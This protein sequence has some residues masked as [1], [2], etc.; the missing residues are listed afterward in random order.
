MREYANTPQNKSCIL[1]S[2][3]KVSEQ[4]SILEILQAYRDRSVQSEVD[5]IR[6]PIVQRVSINDNR[7]VFRNMKQMK[8]LIQFKST[9]YSSD[10]ADKYCKVE[11][12]PSNN[13]AHRVEVDMKGSYGDFDGGT[14]CV[15]IVGW[16]WLSK[17]S[18]KTNWVKFHIWNELL[19]GPGNDLG[20]LIPTNKLINSGGRWKYYE[21]EFKKVAPYGIICKVSVSG[22]YSNRGI[23]TGFPKGLTGDYYSGIDSEWHPIDLDIPCP[24]LSDICDVPPIASRYLDELSAIPARDKRAIRDLQEKYQKRP[25]SEEEDAQLFDAVAIYGENNWI[26]VACNFEFRSKSD[27]SQR[28]MRTLNPQ[29]SC[30]A[31]TSEEDDRLLALV[32]EYGIK[33]WTKVAGRMG[34]RTDVQCRYHCKQLLR[35]RS[36]GE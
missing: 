19:G 12:T 25:W 22:Y 10:N 2:S 4:A 32:G 29:I 26:A 3:P 31:W 11:T 34:N 13:K 5:V 8:D 27:C 18:R 9:I 23:E 21:D 17:E 36:L 20:N 1:D 33:A 14:P 24:E 7:D 30:T 16:S 28:W 35:E 15:N 6:S